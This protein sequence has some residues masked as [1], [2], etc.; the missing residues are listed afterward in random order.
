MDCCGQW[1]SL[2]A[3]K[4]SCQDQAHQRTETPANR[5]SAAVSITTEPRVHRSKGTKELHRASC[6]DFMDLL[7]SL[8][9][10]LA[11]E[12]IPES[13][14]SHHCWSWASPLRGK[15]RAPQCLWHCSYMCL[16]FSRCAFQGWSSSWSPWG[17]GWKDTLWAPCLHQLPI[18]IKLIRN[19]FSETFQACL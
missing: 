18:C 4:F 15:L 14:V 12:K 9:K 17:Q 16:C 11:K 8:M 19:W 6:P 13:T 2:T 7:T 10:A 5:L 3:V 1:I